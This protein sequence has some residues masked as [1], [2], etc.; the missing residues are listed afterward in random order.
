M[1][2][3]FYGLFLWPCHRMWL[4]HLYSTVKIQPF[5]PVFPLADFMAEAFCWLFTWNIIEKGINLF[6]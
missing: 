2:G 1:I 6:L 4:F 5:S 3:A